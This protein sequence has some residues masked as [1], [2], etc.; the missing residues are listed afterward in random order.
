MPP[1]LNNKEGYTPGAQN[2]LENQGNRAF[3]ISLTFAAFPVQLSNTTVGTFALENPKDSGVKTKK[4]DIY[5]WIVLDEP[6][7]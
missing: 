2:L 3:G 1:Y 4:Q 7:L 6:K 5:N